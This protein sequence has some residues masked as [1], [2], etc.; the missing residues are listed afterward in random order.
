MMTSGLQPLPNIEAFTRINVYLKNLRIFG[1][2]VELQIDEVYHETG[3]TES[4][5]MKYQKCI[6]K[7]T[8]TVVSYYKK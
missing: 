3:L 6:H 7:F 4:N 1:L 8:Q 2:E 5:E